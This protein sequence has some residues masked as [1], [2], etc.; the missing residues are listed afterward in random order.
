MTAIWPVQPVLFRFFM[1]LAE[2]VVRKTKSNMVNLFKRNIGLNILAVL[3]HCLGE[4][5]AFLEGE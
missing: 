1:Y 5:E 3:D 2:T 4:H